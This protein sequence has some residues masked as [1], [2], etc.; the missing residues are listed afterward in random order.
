MLTIIIL[1]SGLI[2]N[3]LLFNLWFDTLDKIKYDKTY[4]PESDIIPSWKYFVYYD[5]IVVFTI[6]FIYSIYKCFISGNRK[7]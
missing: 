1:V 4:S 7:S 2:L 3:S 5:C 6:G